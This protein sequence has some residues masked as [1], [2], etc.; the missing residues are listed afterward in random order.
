MFEL[1]QRV[2]DQL[3]QFVVLLDHELLVMVQAWFLRI[4]KAEESGGHSVLC[5][6]E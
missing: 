5:C 3:F 4:V 2:G 1:S 6:Q